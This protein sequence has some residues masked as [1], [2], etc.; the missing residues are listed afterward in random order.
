MTLDPNTLTA[1]QVY[2]YLAA[3]VAPRPICFASTVDAEG[4]RNLSPYSFFNVVSGD[5]PL[6]AFAPLLSGR[7]GSRKDT[8]NNVT[9]VPEVV[10]NVVSHAMVQQMSLASTAYPSATDEFVKAGFTPVAGEAVRPAR[11]AEALVAFECTV[12]RVIALGDGPMAGNLIL[13]RVVRIHVADEIVVGDDGIDHRALDL[14]GRM[15][16]EDYIRAVPEALFTVPKPSRPFGIGV[17]ALPAAVRNSRILTGNDLGQ[18]G[19]QPRLPTAAEL[20]EVM[21]F[22][23]E[24]ERHRMA[25]EQIRVGNPNLALATLLAAG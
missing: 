25:R 11:V 6:L 4:N 15:G 8:L 9:A 5:P 23:S 17:D 24:E 13:A 1:R 3:A 19:N 10:I 18:L 22:G 16:G 7:D 2:Q 14:V 20:A 12:D 21:A